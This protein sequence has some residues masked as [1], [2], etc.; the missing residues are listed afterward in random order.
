MTAVKRVLFLNRSYW[1][2]AEATGQLLTELCED[3]AQSF[4]VTVIAGQPNVDQAECAFRRHGEE[5]RN[6]VCI[7]RVRHTSFPKRSLPGR[8]VNYASFL[9]GALWAALWTKRPDVVVVET[10]PP[11]LCLI[12]W[13]LQR[14]RGAKLICYLQDI[15]PDIGIALGKFRDRWALRILRRLLFYV[16]RHADRVVVLSRDMR[17]R[18]AGPDPKGAPRPRPR[19]GVPGAPPGAAGSRPSASSAFPTGSTPRRSSP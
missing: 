6:G 5:N 16:Y 4:Q 15:H 14:L 8:L 3:L 9:W 11:L 13:C 18:I 19:P 1:P 10:D 2:D 7:R 17:D 12:G